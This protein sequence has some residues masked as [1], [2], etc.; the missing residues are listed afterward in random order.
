MSFCWSPTFERS[1]RNEKVVNE[2]LRLV[3][4]LRKVGRRKTRVK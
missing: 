4:E 1:F 3:I 2:T